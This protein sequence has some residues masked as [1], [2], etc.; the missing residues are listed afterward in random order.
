M[1]LSFKKYLLSAYKKKH[2]PKLTPCIFG[3]P[4]TAVG[5]GCVAGAVSFFMKKHVWGG[6]AFSLGGIAFFVIAWIFGWAILAEYKK[7]LKIIRKKRFTYVRA[8][9]VSKT[10]KQKQRYHDS[11]S[12]EPFGTLVFEANGTGHILTD[13]HSFDR[14]TPG[15]E[16]IL[17]FIKQEGK[18]DAI[19][20]GETRKL[21]YI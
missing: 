14:I 9:C 1:T 5:G 16:Y 6:L 15:T 2:D 18:I 21:L 10:V 13:W 7:V 11:D 8:V 4:F 3:L 20:D 19:C 17:I 12:T